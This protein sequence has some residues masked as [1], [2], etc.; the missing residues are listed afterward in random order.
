MRI[1]RNGLILIMVFVGLTISSHASAADVQATP[2][3]VIAEVEKATGCTK[4]ALDAV[5]K[6][7]PK[8]FEKVSDTVTGIKVMNLILEAKDTEAVAE[9]VRWQI[10][11]GVDEILK[12][13]FPAPMLQ[14]LSAFKA[15]YAALELIRDYMVIPAFD[16]RLYRAYKAQRSGPGGGTPEAAFT[17]ATVMPASGYYLV[18][19]SMLDKYIKSRGWNKEIAGES[20]IKNAEKQI[21]DFWEKRLEARYQKDLAAEQAEKI[22]RQMWN[23]QGATLA[24]IRTAAAAY[25]G[26]PHFLTRSDVDALQGYKFSLYTYWP[27]NSP[28]RFKPT[29]ESHADVVIQ[30]FT[31]IP[32]NV[33]EKKRPDDGFPVCYDA[34]GERMHNGPYVDISIQ[35][36]P[37]KMSGVHQGVPYTIDILEDEKNLSIYN[38]HPFLTVVR[39]IKEPGADFAYLLRK[40]SKD[41]Q[42]GEI[43]HIVMMFTDTSRFTIG[44]SNYNL[45][46]QHDTEALVMQI[47]RMILNKTKK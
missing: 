16:E 46:Q 31:V 35:M 32:K 14:A 6:E 3:E 21:D 7:S 1:M 42:G 47:M 29:K 37:R 43:G 4:D 8:L 39:E 24:A 27:P 22:K 11:K 12:K 41:G 34:R 5:M 9:V 15:Y 30:S 33:T 25:G 45:N 28:D 38:S 20:M 36:I 23:A 17:E 18:K 40:A 19:P 26:Y 13:V 2:E 10:G 44:A